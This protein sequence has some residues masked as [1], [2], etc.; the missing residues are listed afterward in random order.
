MS[1]SLSN[2]RKRTHLSSPPISSDPAIFSS[3]DDDPSAENYTQERRKKK[4]YRGPWYRQRPASDESLESSQQKK[5][6]RTFERK[7]DSGVF[8][9]SDGTD[10][11]SSIEE[12]LVLKHY[13]KLLPLRQSRLASL[14]EARPASPEDIA[15]N[16]I[17]SCLEEGLET[18]DLS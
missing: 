5:S 15:K 4:N 12:D 7:F 6:K 3:S 13:G 17:D 1:Q 8:M 14:R 10:V 11:D 9:G 16:Q 18:I 2:H